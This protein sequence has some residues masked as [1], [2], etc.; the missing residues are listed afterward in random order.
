MTRCERYVFVESG[1]IWMLAFLLRASCIYDFIFHILFAFDLNELQAVL[2][3]TASKKLQHRCALGR[4]AP[5]RMCKHANEGAMRW[6]REHGNSFRFSLFIS[7][8]SYFSA[9]LS[10][11][12]RNVSISKLTHHSIHCVRFKTVAIDAG[13]YLIIY[14]RE[15]VV[16]KRV[17]SIDWWQYSVYLPHLCHSLFFSLTRTLAFAYLPF[18]FQS[19]RLIDE[20]V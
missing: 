16:V 3:L 11:A 7:F 6:T 18:G 20:R 19:P 2:M 12:G 10:D 17:R 14:I 13:V 4:W 1:C 15:F 9:S 8:S 5:M